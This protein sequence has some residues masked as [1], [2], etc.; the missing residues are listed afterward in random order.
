MPLQQVWTLSRPADQQTAAQHV[1]LIIFLAI[2][3]GWIIIAL[4]TR[5]LDNFSYGY[6]GLNENST[7]DALL[8]AL[9]VTIFFI[10][11]IWVVDNYNI[12]EPTGGVAS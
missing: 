1:F 8:I 9:M 2:V 12:A 10:V 4:W 5:V 3:I 7:W 11:L 6:L